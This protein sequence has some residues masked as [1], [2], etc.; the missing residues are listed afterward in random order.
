MIFIFSIVISRICQ[1]AT[2]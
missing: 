1:S 2:C